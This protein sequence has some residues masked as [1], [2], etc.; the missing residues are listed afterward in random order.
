MRI[1]RHIF[2]SVRGYTTLAHSPGV[3]PEDCRALE[4]AAFTFGQT[5]DPRFMQTLDARPAY[6]TRVLPGPRRALTRVLPG[7]PD[8]NG[9]A[10]LTLVTAILTLDEWNHELYGDVH[11]LLTDPHVWRW[12]EGAPLAPIDLSA[13]RPGRLAGPSDAGRVLRLIADLESSR[14]AHGRVVVSADD[15]TLADLA[16]VEMLIPAAMRTTVTTAYRSLGPRLAVSVNAVSDSRLAPGVVRYAGVDPDELPPYAESLLSLGLTGA[17]PLEHV[18]N[19][20]SFNSPSRG[21]DPM[22]SSASSAYV[23]SSPAATRAAY[24]SSPARPP[25]PQSSS[26]P[27]LPLVMVC[28]LSLVLA[29]GALVLARVLSQ[30]DARQLA[31]ELAKVRQD[32]A[33]AHAKDAR[34]LRDQVTDARAKA[35]NDLRSAGED[36][37][38]RLRALD[39]KLTRNMASA[40]EASAVEASRNLS[41]LRT[42]VGELFLLTAPQVQAQLA[43]ADTRRRTLLDQLKK[44]GMAADKAEPRR[45]SQD[46]AAV[47]TRAK[48]W[49]AAMRASRTEPPPEVYVQISRATEELERHQS[50]L[51]RLCAWWDGKLVQREP[52]APP[53]EDAP[54]FPRD[55]FPE[56]VEPDSA[57]LKELSTPASKPA[58]PTTPE[59]RPALTNPKKGIETSP[60]KTDPSKR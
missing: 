30:Q 4:A 29:G 33:D 1:Q 15:Y 43:D 9:R 31:A 24:V 23:P 47:L 22:A 6:F 16:N 26:I 25:T 39:D 18:M 46:I 3:S 13:S 10:T 2:G 34:D 45:V 11:R 12:D 40:A 7:R 42:A 21:G 17:P 14:G 38:K 32:L 55:E 8:D 57:L 20:P 28:L 36:Q 53:P 54:K 51:L 37:T 35:A 50:N 52:G 5:N 19:Y 49:T 59:T 27:V 60:K 48:A 58:S 56:L 41:E 44:K